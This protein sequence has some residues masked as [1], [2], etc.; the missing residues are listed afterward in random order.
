[1]EGKTG[2]SDYDSAQGSKRIRVHF[3]G[4]GHEGRRNARHSAGKNL[5]SHHILPLFQT[6]QTGEKCDSGVHGNGVL[7]QR[8]SGDS[9]RNVK[10]LVKKFV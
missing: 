2:E 1:M 8:R 9:G 6:E 7:P 5:R 4:R 3:E 10:K